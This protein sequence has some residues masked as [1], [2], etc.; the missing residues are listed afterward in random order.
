VPADSYGKPRTRID[1]K[2]MSSLTCSRWAFLPVGGLLVAA[3]LAA[4]LAEDSDQFASISR[5]VEEAMSNHSV[6]GTGVAVI[7]EFEVVR[8]EGLGFAEP[9]REV[10]TETL[11]QAA[12]LT[13][14]GS[15]VVAATAAEE[16]PSSFSQMSLWPSPSVSPAESN[17]RSRT[18]SSEFVR[19]LPRSKPMGR[20]TLALGSPPTDSEG[21]Y[22][23]VLTPVR[24]NV[25]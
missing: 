24:S 1:F 2:L 6:L 18:G 10:N 5:T 13:K 25:T 17:T 3:T 9:G 15:A 14:P 11:F 23:R 22:S 8:A 19:L 7:D 20:R 12:S 4:G 21:V 16:D